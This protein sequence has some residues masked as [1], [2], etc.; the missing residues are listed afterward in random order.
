MRF[1]GV[2]LVLIGVDQWKGAVGGVSPAPLLPLTSRE[3]VV[4]GGR[5]RGSEPDSHPHR[6][7]E[8]RDHASLL[9]F[10]FYFQRLVEWGAFRAR[11]HHRPSS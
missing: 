5:M 9:Y 4:G 8:G 3:Q 1:P 6:L 2:C 7:T 11:Q 10:S